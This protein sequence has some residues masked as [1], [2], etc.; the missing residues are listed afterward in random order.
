MKHCVGQWSFHMLAIS[1]C[2]LL[3]HSFFPFLPVLLPSQVQCYLMHVTWI[4][5]P[6]TAFI[7]HDEN[8]DLLLL[9]SDVHCHIIL[10][11]RMPVCLFTTRVEDGDNIITMGRAV[12]WA[13]MQDI[14]WLQCSSCE[15]NEIR[16]ILRPL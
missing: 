15:K 1:I 2:S 5:L 3:L 9:E 13:L 14:V 11:S 16:D 10:L 8:N 6:S 12:Y 7:V 4:K